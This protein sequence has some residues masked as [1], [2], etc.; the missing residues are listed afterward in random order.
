MDRWWEV[1]NDLALVDV[2]RKRIRGD[3]EAQAKFYSHLVGAGRVAGLTDEEIH[4]AFM[5]D[6]MLTIYEP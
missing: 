4:D 6:R 3:K 2:I 1:G 5:S